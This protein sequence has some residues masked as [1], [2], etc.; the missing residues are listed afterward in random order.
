MKDYIPDL[1]R[2][3]TAFFAQAEAKQILAEI[4]EALDKH[5]TAYELSP[6]SWKLTFQK[7]REAPTT[8]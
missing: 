3:T 5:D 7:Q 4:T 8:R 2:K 6:K 1:T